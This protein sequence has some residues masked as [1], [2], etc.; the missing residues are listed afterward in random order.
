MIVGLAGVIANGSGVPPYGTL[1]SQSCT[2]TTISDYYGNSYTGYYNQ[3]QVYADGVGGTYVNDSVGGS[4]C[5]YPNGYVYSNISGQ[6]DV[7]WS[8][9]SN[10]GIFNA[11]SISQDTVADGAGGTYT[12]GGISWSYSSGH[13]IYDSGGMS[14]CRVILDTSVYPYYYIQTGG[15]ADPYGTKY[16]LP[17]W[18]SSAMSLYMT[19]ADGYGGV[20]NTN[21]DN[22]P[23]YPSYGTQV[24]SYTYSCN[25][26]PDSIGYNWYLCFYIN[27]Y[28]D[29]VGGSYST[30]TPDGNY[31]SGYAL[32]G[33]QIF[34]DEF[35]YSWYVYDNSYQW[36]YPWKYGYIRADGYGGSNRSYSSA[37][38]NSVLSGQFY[39]E[40]GN[41]GFLAADGSGGYFFYNL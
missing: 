41:Y 11:G 29:G 18:E 37:P 5:H 15:G 33:L 14:W 12:S 25:Y 24:A 22:N 23:P 3:H 34:T 35:D 20:I 1:L 30:S 27:Y 9:C 31:P 17:Y 38:Y 40:Y 21:W 26:Y 6:F 7:N 2:I 4:P 10:N 16:G 32:S 13:I 28:A 19:I 39:N 36:V 8:G